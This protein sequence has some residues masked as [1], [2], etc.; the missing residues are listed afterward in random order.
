MVESCEGEAFETTKI[1]AILGNL[2]ESE[3]V[4]AGGMEPDGIF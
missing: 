2:E 4:E 1:D 3:E